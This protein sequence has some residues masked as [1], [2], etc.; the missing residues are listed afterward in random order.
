MAYIYIYMY[1]EIHRDVHRFSLMFTGFHLCVV[2]TGVSRS[3]PD[4]TV[5]FCSHP[6]SFAPVGKTQSYQTDI[7][8]EQQRLS[9]FVGLNAKSE[10]I[11]DMN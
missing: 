9:L 6:D 5:F 4:F 2:F 11:L 8:Y 1:R 7:K 10:L 3:S